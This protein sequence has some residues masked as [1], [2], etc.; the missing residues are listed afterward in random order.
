MSCVCGYTTAGGSAGKSPPAG[1]RVRR[2]VISYAVEPMSFDQR[3]KVCSWIFV[4]A[5]LHVLGGLAAGWLYFQE[6][7]DAVMAIA[8]V[9]SAFVMAVGWWAAAVAIALLAELVARSRED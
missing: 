6:R 9:L 2:G 8:G 4:V 7:I 3:P 5:W 1:A